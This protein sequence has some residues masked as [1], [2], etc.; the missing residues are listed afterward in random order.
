MTPGGRGWGTM[1]HWNKRRVQKDGRSS[2]SE[3]RRA[4]APFGLRPDVAPPATSR[5]GSAQ[6]LV[7]VLVV[8]ALALLVLPQV[9][10]LA[11]ASHPTLVGDLSGQGA[12][13]YLSTA[14]GYYK[15]RPYPQLPSFPQTSATVAPTVTVVTRARGPV[16]S[17]SYQIVAY[18]SHAAVAV[19]VRRLGRSTLELKP[20]HSLAPGRYFVQVPADNASDN[21][22]FFYFQVVASSPTPSPSP[23]P[24][25]TVTPTPTPSE[26]VTPTPTPS[27]TATPDVGSSA[28]AAPAAPDPAP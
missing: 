2:A 1:T 10:R 19:N 20:A 27:D 26:T 8:V 21:Q 12:G 5:F 28:A 4:A 14:G 15:L 23:T 7:A 25:E 24:S 16:R 18:S 13:A 6:A 9:L 11:R 3:R 17:D 22:A